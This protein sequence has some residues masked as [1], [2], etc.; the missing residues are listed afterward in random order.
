MAEDSGTNS[1]NSGWG[2]PQD[3]GG[4]PVP[5]QVPTPPTRSEPGYQP[6][7]FPVPPSAASPPST[8]PPPSVGSPPPPTPASARPLP[9]ALP[10]AYG[11]PA[12]PKKTNWRKWLLILAV[13]VGVLLLGIAACIF[14]FVGAV[15]APVDRANDFLA[16]VNAE[17][18][19][20]AVAHTD[21]NCSTLSEAWLSQT[22][23]NAE[24][25]YNLNAS[26]VSGDGA[27]VAGTLGFN[28]DPAVDIGM[29]M[30]K[31]DGEWRVCSVQLPF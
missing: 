11:T 27:M 10:P 28:N 16:E 6:G 30:Q 2:P 3:S 12:P 5:P 26:S 7:S 20:E 22:F 24:L 13:I 18:W 25:S 14:A 23:G 17:N 4:G 1:G 21:P 29:T 9:A 8:A 31:S 19:S 15:T